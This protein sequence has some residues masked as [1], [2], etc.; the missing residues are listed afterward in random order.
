MMYQFRGFV[1]SKEGSAVGLLGVE[2]IA[3]LIPVTVEPAGHEE[4]DPQIPMSDPERFPSIRQMDCP[5]TTG[6]SHIECFGV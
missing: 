5:V 6:R 1:P 3:H 4:S 2:V